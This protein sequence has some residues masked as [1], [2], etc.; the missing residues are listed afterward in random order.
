MISDEK[1]KKYIHELSDIY[2]LL[3]DAVYGHEEITVLHPDTQKVMEL[4]VKFRDT[5]CIALRESHTTKNFEDN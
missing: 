1:F 3:K 5:A 2:E 4:I